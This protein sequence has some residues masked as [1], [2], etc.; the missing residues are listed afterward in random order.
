MGSDEAIL[1]SFSNNSYVSG[2]YPHLQPGYWASRAEP[3]SVY[4]CRSKDMCPGGPPQSCGPDMEDIAC[5]VCRKGYFRQG[6]KCESCTGLDNTEFNYPTLQILVWPF[7]VLLL[8][9]FMWDQVEQWGS[10]ANE[11]WSV[12][13]VVL[14]HYQILGLIVSS[15][16][17]W[18][19]LIVDTLYVWEYLVDVWEMLRLECIGDSAIY[20]GFENSYPVKTM[21]PLFL[22]A[23]FGGFY[24]IG[25]I[26]A[27]LGMCARKSGHKW[28][29]GFFKSCG[30]VRFT[31]VD[32]KM[33]VDPS[34]LFNC[35]MAVFQAFYIS[36]CF[37]SLQLF[38][39]YEH[40][41]GK[42]T[43]RFGPDVECNS[44]DWS[45]MLGEA[46]LM[47]L[48][49]NA[50]AVAAMIV[51][52]AAAPKFFIR[53]RFRATWKFM[54]IKWRPDVWWWGPVVMIRA[55]LLCLTCDVSGGTAPAPLATGDPDRL[56]QLRGSTQTVE[57]LVCKRSRLAGD[58]ITHLVHRSQLQL[59][60][61]I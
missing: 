41:N 52:A 27:E 43:L 11:M 47:M 37:I 6:R 14:V 8:Y 21:Q 48:P 3:L 30:M 4:L 50:G 32:P 26:L 53:K 38:M 2:Q 19:P 44:E 56:R 18:E 46:I 7:V 12:A 20:R 55:L 40:P 23:I 60:A 51:A 35:Y 24:I 29:D 58:W 16:V 57:E 34:V 59:R 15:S 61:A 33:A 13:F 49:I 28:V 25:F 22:V 42:S 54:F 39:C 31:K 36:F 9:Y 5:S 1:R 45:M 10:Y 17:P